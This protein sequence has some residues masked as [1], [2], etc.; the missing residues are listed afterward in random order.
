MTRGTILS[1]SR[2][3]VVA[4]AV[5]RVG[6]IGRYKLGAGGSNPESKTPY[7]L[8]QCDCSGFV[9]WCLGLDRWQENAFGKYGE[10]LSTT[11]MVQDGH[12]LS[13]FFGWTT[14]PTPGDVIVYPS[15]YKNGK[16][17]SI[18]HCGIFVGHPTNSAR[19]V[20]DC[21]A[22]AVRRSGGSAIGY[23][24]SVGFMKKPQWCILKYNRFKVELE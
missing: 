3:E 16:R 11:S 22:S 14:E 15:I 2:D 17:I 8:G 5:S 13:V 9:S 18:G 1:L 23:T 12:G 4:R 6:D 24:S 21:N 10:Y 20:I 19:T 7:V